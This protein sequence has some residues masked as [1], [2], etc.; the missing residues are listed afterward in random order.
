MKGPSHAFP[1]VVWSASAERSEQAKVKSAYITTC[2][3]C[4]L[5][6]NVQ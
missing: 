1:L 5:A 3:L 2:M 6:S 4:Q